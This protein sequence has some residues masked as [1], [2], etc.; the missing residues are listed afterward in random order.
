MYGFCKN[1]HLCGMVGRTKSLPKYPYT[2]SEICEYV[3]FHGKK[4]LTCVVK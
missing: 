1:A 4:D 3:T 2:N